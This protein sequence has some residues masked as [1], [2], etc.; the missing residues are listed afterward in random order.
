MNEYSFIF[1][2]IAFRYHGNKKK[3]SFFLKKMISSAAQ[4]GC[5]GQNEKVILA[6]AGS[7]SYCLF[8][9]VIFGGK[10]IL[11]NNERQ[12]VTAYNK[13]KAFPSACINLSR[14]HYFF[15]LFSFSAH[16]ATML[17]EHS[18]FVDGLYM[19]LITISTVGY[20]EVVHLS[21]AGRLFTMVL[22]LIGVGFVMFVFT[23]ITEAVVEGELRAVY[24]RLHMKKKVGDLS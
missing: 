5:E 13:T 20:G 7:F 23:K 6:C 18:T 21:P 17:L 14:Q 16:A 3:A 12:G 10:D 9:S 2:K 4:N 24:G 19:T 1:Y 15:L 22:I 8:F 11:G